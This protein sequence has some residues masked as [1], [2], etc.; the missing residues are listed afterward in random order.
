M[1]AL[2]LVTGFIQRTTSLWLACLIVFSSLFVSQKALA[3][4]P[5]EVTSKTFNY[6][7]NGQTTTEG[8]LGHAILCSLAG[9]SPLGKCAAYTSQGGQ[10]KLMAYDKIPTGG[11]L[12]ALGS[13]TAMLYSTPPTSTAYYLANLG[14]SVGISIKPAYAQ[15][16]PGLG[17]GQG[18]IAP[19]LQIW[20]ITRN[21]AYLAFIVV[22]LVVGFMIMFRQKI[23][24]Q[25]VISVQQA[26]P[27]MVVGLILVTFSY[28]I[29]SL[30]VDLA[31]VG[32]QLVAGIFSGIPNSLGSSSQIQN[33]SQ[34][35]NI[36]QLYWSA[37]LN[38]QNLW[39][40]GSSVFSQLGTTLSGPT[41]VAAGAVAA[42]A[43]G[44]FAGAIIGN[45]PGAIIGG[46]AGLASPV[47]I[48]IVI[49]VIL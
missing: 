24:Q 21:L 45:I 19:V 15:A 17:T 44:A 43:I 16:P 25:T 29:A 47:I 13:A 8:A 7:I 11:A 26:I 49:I 32:I 2:K 33:L 46:A 38:G 35:N 41:G 42:G 30:L 5:E 31:F 9:I 1:T 34:N 48:P 22:F 14:E 23:N 18:V 27:S 28:F 40:A 37:G 6:L 20:Q 10:T 3:I 39:M 4:N 12:G 36:F